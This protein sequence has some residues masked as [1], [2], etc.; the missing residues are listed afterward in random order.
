M[1]II[2][3]T[4][5]STGERSALSEDLSSHFVA[6]QPPLSFAFSFWADALVT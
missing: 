3:V 6:L 4:A 1:G 2:T 5:A